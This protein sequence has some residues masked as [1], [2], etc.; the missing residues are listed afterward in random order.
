MEKIKLFYFFFTTKI[1][2]NCIVVIPFKIFDQPEPLNFSID[3]VI[4]NWSRIII[5]ANAS[6]GTPAQKIN[7]IIDSNSFSSNLF[8][9]MCDIPNSLYNN[10]KSSTFRIRQS[11]I[12]YP[13]VKAYIIDENIY[14]YTDI[15]MTEI[16]PYKSI[17]I[18]YSD[19]KK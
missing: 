13:M 6:I 3:N 10:T 18:I 8:Q 7:M 5:Y 17:K 15:K 2:I 1:L 11:V 19:N 16:K 4:K 14:F 12:Y 9:H